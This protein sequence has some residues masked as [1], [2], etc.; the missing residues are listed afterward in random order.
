MN[1]LKRLK[2]QILHHQH[3][4]QARTQTPP[5]QVSPA[6]LAN[7]FNS[8]FVP[9]STPRSIWGNAWKGIKTTL[10]LVKDS[11]DAFPPLKSTAGGLIGLIDLIEVRPFSVG[12]SVEPYMHSEYSKK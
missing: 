6:S 7:V 1:R 2:H 8:P 11:A 10:R 12:L 5:S 4:S 3:N 9:Q